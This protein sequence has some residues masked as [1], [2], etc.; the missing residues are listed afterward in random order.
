[1][2]AQNWNKDWQFEAVQT[3]R[4]YP[5]TLPHDGMI[6]TDRDPS[7]RN[8]FLSAGFLG[9]TYQYTK[10]FFAPAQWRGKMVLVE[11]ESVYCNTTVAL[12]G[13]QLADHP[14]GFTPIVVDLTDQLRFGEHNLLTVTADVPREGHNRWYTGGESIVPSTCLWLI[15]DISTCTG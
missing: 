1:M 7:I 5:V 2:N 14:Y 8:Y 4:S 9:E 13:K 15:S 3:G 12:N 11:L 10:R 6:H